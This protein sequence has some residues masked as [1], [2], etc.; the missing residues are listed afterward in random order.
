M[1]N[2]IRKQ[3]RVK[4]SLSANVVLS[5][6]IFF[7][8]LIFAIFL[9]VVYAYFLSSITINIAHAKQSDASARE[10]TSEIATL[11]VEY[12]SSVGNLDIE[13]AYTRGF[14]EV[15]DVK[16]VY[17]KEKAPSVALLEE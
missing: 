14:R 15:K 17:T 5:R 12:L 11:E 6:K 4:N 1:T 10:L 13:E 7:T 16:F 9:L 8:L 3:I 2:L